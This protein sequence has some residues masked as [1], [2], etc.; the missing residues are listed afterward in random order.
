MRAI[1][2]GPE[3]ASLTRH[4]AV[5]GATYKDKSFTPFKDDIRDALLAEQLALCCYCTRRIAKEVRPLPTRQNGP[6]SPQMKIE[7]WQSQTGFPARQLDWSNLLGACLGGMGTP[8]TAHTCDTSKAGNSVALTPLD[9]AH[10]STLS[11]SNTGHLDSTDLVFQKDIDERLCLNYRV[12]VEERKA[13]IDNALRLLRARYPTSKI[14]ESAIR[15]MIEEQEAP[16][17]GK[18]PALAGVL[19][20]WARQQFDGHW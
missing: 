12:L 6:S 19:R 16:V 2:K 3:P 8:K 13:C 9:A 7:H 4:R 10:I 14:P 1:H 18:L 11:C 20:L 15:S 5:P 17:N